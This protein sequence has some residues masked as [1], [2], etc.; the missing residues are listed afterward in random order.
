MAIKILGICGSP[1]KGG[2][3]ET[4]LDLALKSAAEVPDVETE[5][6]NVA[7]KKFM[8]CLHCNWCLNKQ[9]EGPEDKFCAQKDDVSPLYPKIIEADGL[10]IAT[11]VYFHRCSWQTA[12]V[13]DRQR[14]L[15]EGKRYRRNPV[16]L[17]KVLGGL[18]VAWFRNSG[19]ETALLV[20]HEFATI[21]GALEVGGVAAVSSLD[22]TGRIDLEAP[23]DKLLV[24]RDERVVRGTRALGKRIAEVCRKL[25]VGEEALARMESE[26]EVVG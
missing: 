10:L 24:L 9:T 21:I 11:P 13:I 3:T 7:H 25:K 1:I 4:I 6:F 19:L 16:L 26:T 22:G 15:V 17:D 18:A 14:C 2:N 8:G 20:I 12:A 23:D 5:M